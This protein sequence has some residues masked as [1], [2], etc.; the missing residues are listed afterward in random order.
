MDQQ[1][2]LIPSTQ[3]RKNKGEHNDI[4]S[5]YRKCSD[6]NNYNKLTVTF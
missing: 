2:D 4:N 6:D 3:N 1:F 5:N